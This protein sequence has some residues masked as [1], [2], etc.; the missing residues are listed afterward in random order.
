M[1]HAPRIREISLATVK[2]G[3][4]LSLFLNKFIITGRGEGIKKRKYKHRGTHTTH[5]QQRAGRDLSSPGGYYSTEVVLVH[6]K[7]NDKEKTIND[8]LAF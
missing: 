3:P 1:C 8:D 2:L 4:V 5:E 7:W 6:R